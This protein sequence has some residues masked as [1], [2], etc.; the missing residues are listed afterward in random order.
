MAQQVA[1]A[2]L[3]LVNAKRRVA[4]VLKNPEIAQWG[5]VVA[6]DG[7]KYI[8]YNHDQLSAALPKLDASATFATLQD[9]QGVVLHPSTDVQAREK[10]ITPVVPPAEHVDAVNRAFQRDLGLA[11]RIGGVVGEAMAWMYVHYNKS[12]VIVGSSYVCSSG[13]EEYDEATYRDNQGQCPVHAGATL[14]RKP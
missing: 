2:T 8:L 4:E 9:V 10:E 13:G 12:F 14:S 7:T 11:P 5:G 6:T 1:L 3:P